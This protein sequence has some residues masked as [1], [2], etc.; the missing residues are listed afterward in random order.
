MRWALCGVGFGV[1]MM[2]RVEVCGLVGDLFASMFCSCFKIYNPANLLKNSTIHQ[3]N[4][5]I[6]PSN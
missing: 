6:K 1:V 5:G 2:F 4:H 3:P